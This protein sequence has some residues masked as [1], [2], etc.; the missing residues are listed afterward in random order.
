AIKRGAFDYLVKPVD[1]DEFELTIQ[2]AL[3][4]AGL[5]NEVDRLRQ[6]V[7]RLQQ[8]DHLIGLNPKFLEAQMLA[9]KSARSRDAGVLLQGESGVG[10]ELFARLI[11]ARSPRADYPFVALNC[12]A[13]SADIIESE[14]FGYEKGA[15][16]GARAEGKQGLLEVADGG[17]LF[18]DEVIDL[19]PEIQ[20]KLLRVLEEKEFYPLGAT[21]KRTVDIRILSA[22]NTDLWQAGEEGKFRRDL[23]FRLATIRIDLPPLRERTEDILPLVR[24]FMEDFNDKYG[25]RFRRLSP[26]AERLLLAHSWPGNV[27]ELK[28]TIERV[29]LLENEETILANHLHFLVSFTEARSPTV[30]QIFR[31]EFPEQGI[32]LDEIEKHVI[33]K[34]YERCQGNKSKTARFLSIPRHVLIYRLKKFGIED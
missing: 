23:F 26:E 7:Q 3:E 31:V 22:C 5:R 17:T 25:K 1:L 16:T 33:L 8:V 21:R 34:A 15:F 27:R 20:A 29:V 19:H 32:A 9:V 30:S 4:H 24:F 6:E 10:K 11:H 2:T 18:L 12:A 28:N 13:F 14:L